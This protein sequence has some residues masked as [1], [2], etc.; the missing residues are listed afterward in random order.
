MQNL[1]VPGDPGGRANTKTAPASRQY[2]GL[3][4]GLEKLCL[5]PLPRPEPL[6]L[7]IIE[8]VGLVSGVVRPY[9]LCSHQWCVAGVVIMSWPPASGQS[10][11]SGHPVLLDL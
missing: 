11:R 8:L 3:H 7:D 6:T 2:L 10:P 9:L 1:Q 4:I 5:P